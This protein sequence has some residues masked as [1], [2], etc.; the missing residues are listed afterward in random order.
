MSVVAATYGSIWTYLDGSKYWYIYPFN[1]NTSTPLPQAIGL[2][3]MSWFIVLMNFVPV[4][5]LITLELVNFIQA[6]F[7][8]QDM[9]MIDEE[10]QGMCAKVQSSNLNEEL[11]MVHYIFSDKTGT[12]T[13][14]VM[15]FK[16]FSAG[17][18]E[19][20]SDSVDEVKYAPGVTNV[21]FKDK[22]FDDHYNN[23][24]HDNHKTLF[25]FLEAIGLCHTIIAEKNTDTAT[26]EEYVSYNA[27]SPDELAIVNGA[28][29]LGF[30]FV[31]RDD[32][33]N[34]LCKTKHGDKGYK[35]LNL[36]EF[37]STRKRMS[38][39]V[40]TPE[41]QIKCICKGADSIIEKRLKKNTHPRLLKRT[42]KYLD[43]YA[44]LGLRTL[45]IASKDVDEEFYSKWSKQMSLAQKSINK[46]KEINK[47]AELIE[48]DFEL[49]GSTAIED[50][51]Q[52]E[53]G[54]TIYDIKKAGVQLW[55]LTGDKVETAINIG[56]SCQLLHSEM[57]MFVL[58]ET[59]PRRVRIEI[60]NAIAQQKV[61][62]KARDNAVIVA[63]DT[64]TTIQED[65]ELVKEFIDLCEGANVVLACR[66]SPN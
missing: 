23:E 26:G 44:K 13:Q 10:K 24:S 51:L 48:H 62:K 29:H 38:V 46:E 30:G 54:R 37:D 55:V 45:L 1:D 56:F 19:Y 59:K 11:G 2:Q 33:G 50:K 5:L 3:T 63:G 12:L 22:R 64:L 57:N 18:Y 58:E 8:E 14:N 43:G 66:V 52:E 25:K 39:I 42:T 65:E 41:G 60:N 34:M 7:I 27:S 20:G 61:T 21:N 47:V 32:D 6:Y 53:V 9:N 17:I 28:R 16:R 49:L 4:S 35:L 36:I 31:G 40:R 15:E